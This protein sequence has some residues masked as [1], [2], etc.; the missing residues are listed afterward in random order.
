MKQESYEVLLIPAFMSLS[1][2]II[3]GI[4][5]IISVY[6]RE[7]LKKK[8]EKQKAFKILYAN[9]VI[10]FEEASRHPAL[11]NM[12]IAGDEIHNFRLNISADSNPKKLEEFLERLNNVEKILQ[13]KDAFSEVDAKKWQ[14]DIRSRSNKEIELIYEEINRILENIEHGNQILANDLIGYLP[15]SSAIHVLQVKRAANAIYTIVKSLVAA[16][17]E[18]ENLEP[19][20]VRKEVAKIISSLILASQQFVPLVN[21]CKKELKIK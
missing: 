3:A 12:L 13:A 21:A 2:V 1:G 6:F 20:H 10:F 8:N 4:I 19:D 16:L 5:T 14:D 18:R 17:H 15:P 9:L 7:N 11:R